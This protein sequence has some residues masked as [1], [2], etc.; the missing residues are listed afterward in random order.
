VDLSTVH[1][2]RTRNIEAAD[3]VRALVSTPRGAPLIGVGDAFAFIGFD[4]AESD[5][6]LQV[7]FPLLLSNL[8]EF[9]VPA[10]DGLLPSSMRL[11]EAITVRVDPRLTQVQLVDG[12]ERRSLAVVGGSVTIPGADGVRIRELWSDS[13]LPDGTDVPELGGR[14]G[15]TA[16]NLFSPDESDV[17]PGD[18]QRIVDMGRVPADAGPPPQPARTE[19]WWPLVLAA[20]ALLAVEWLLFH[21]PSRQRLARAMRRRPQALAGPAK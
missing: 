16:V 14:L 18:P 21:R 20:L 2:G 12:T 11:G 19:W 8:V 4:L 1:V 6:P 7:A 13:T 5:L 9:V 15:M 10:A 17:A 3:G